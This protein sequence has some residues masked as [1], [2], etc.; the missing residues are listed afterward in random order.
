MASYYVSSAAYAAVAQYANLHLYALNAIIRQLAAP[1]FGS[2]RVFICTTGG[3]SG[4]SEPAWNLTD[5]STT[6]AGTAVFTE[7]SG[8]EANQANA[9]WKAPCANIQAWFNKFNILGKLFVSTDHSEQPA[10]STTYNFPAGMQIIAVSRG[11]GS[12][13]PPAVADVATGTPTAFVGATLNN[14]CTWTAAYTSGLII[15]GGTSTG[16][17]APII[18]PRGNVMTMEHCQI[19]LGGTGGGQIQVGAGDFGLMVLNDVAFSFAATAGQATFNGFCK[20]EWNNNNSAAVVGSFAPTTFF[21]SG[22]GQS[23]ALRIRGVDWTAGAGVTNIFAVSGTN[24]STNQGPV[25]FEDCT[26]LSGKNFLYN[27]TALGATYKPGTD[28]TFSNC[29]NNNSVVAFCHL[30]E[31]GIMSASAVGSRSGGAAQSSGV[32][33]GHIWQRDSNAQ[34]SFQNPYRGPQ[35][36]VPN[37]VTGSSKT[38]TLF[39]CSTTALDNAQ[40]WIEAE[41]LESA[42]LVGG[43]YHSTRMGLQD[44]PTGLTTD[45]SDWTSG[46]TAARANSNVYAAGT[47]IKLASNPTRLFVCTSGGTSASSEPGGYASAVDGGT[48]TDGTAVFTCMFRYK[49]TLTFTPGRVGIVKVRPCYATT[50]SVGN[51]IV[52]CDP[53]PTIT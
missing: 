20:I 23:I 29:A 10:A 33:Y 5:G 17:G 39:L 4:A 49:I 48:V 30:T 42:T 9:N 15:S 13:V 22:T 8:R 41:T 44:T 7:I 46:T 14:G 40:A 28:W 16:S 47:F 18:R 32:T 38:L 1:A 51:N 31:R 50:G 52:I 12:T 26:L 21:A 3:T 19:D 35:Y 43:S 25:R 27:N 6:T 24:V 2:E 37:T 53:Q 11:V 45:T 34:C 36:Y